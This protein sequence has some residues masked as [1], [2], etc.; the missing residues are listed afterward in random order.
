M[1]N[2]NNHNVLTNLAETSNNTSE[3]AKN[4]MQVIAKIIGP[5]SIDQA[6]AEGHK[7]WH[8]RTKTSP[9]IGLGFVYKLC[10]NF[11]SS[12]FTVIPNRSPTKNRVY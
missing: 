1:S 10:M 4:F 11:Y 8:T 5:D 9:E 3:T 12:I 2:R 7:I 6:V